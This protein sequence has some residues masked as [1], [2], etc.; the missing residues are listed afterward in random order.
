VQF[1]EG[2]LTLAKDGGR[3]GDPEHEKPVT[4]DA[5]G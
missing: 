4:A 2:G 3:P 1:S 5:P